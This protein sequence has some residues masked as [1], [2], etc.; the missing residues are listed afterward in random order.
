MI[1]SWPG[2]SCISNDYEL[3]RMG[4]TP[5]T[6]NRHYWHRSAARLKRDLNL[7]DDVSGF[8]C[9]NSRHLLEKSAC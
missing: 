1:L 9:V 4:K 5:S 8:R 7:A 3:A 2:S 6:T